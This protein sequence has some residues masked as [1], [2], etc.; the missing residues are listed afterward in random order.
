MA[1]IAPKSVDE[2]SHDPERMAHAFGLLASAELGRWPDWDGADAPASLRARIEVL[3]ILLN[4]VPRSEI[5]RLDELI[6]AWCREFAPGRCTTAIELR[7][8]VGRVVRP[9]RAKSDHPTLDENSFR[10]AM[11]LT[12]SRENPVTP[13]A[14]PEPSPNDFSDKQAQQQCAFGLGVWLTQVANHRRWRYLP[15]IVPGEAATEIDKAYVELYAISDGDAADIGDAAQVHSKRLPRRMLASQYP[16]VSVPTMV[17]RTMHRCIVMGEPGGGKSTLVQWLAWATHNNKCPDFDVAL[18]VKLSAFAAALAEKPALSLIEFF[19]DSLDTNIVDWCPGAYW[20]RRL[21]AESH[22][23]LL[24]LD[25]WDEVPLP[26]REAVREQIERESHAFVT[27]ITSRPSGLPRQFRDG[28]SVDFYHIAGLASGAIENLVRKLLTS[29]GKPELSDPILTRIR[30]EP[31]L[32]EMA[33]NPFLLGLLVRVLTRVSDQGVVPRTRSEVYRQITSWVQELHN[34]SCPQALQLTVEHFAALRRLSHALLFEV[35]LPRY[36]FRSR[37]LAERLSG[38][39]LEPILR[40]R[41]V[42]RVDPVF[43][44]FAFLHATLQEYFAAE[45]AGTLAPQQLDEMMDR[46]FFS[47]SRLI[48]LEFIAGLEGRASVQCREKVVHWF[49]HR[50]R[51]QQ[52]LFRVARIA[53]AGRWPADD[54]EGFGRS[55]R[56]ALCAEITQSQ[57][58][59][60]T[61]EAIGVFA[62]LDPIDLARRARENRNLD[63]WAIRCCVDSVPRPIG[64]KERL[65]ELVGEEWKDHGKLDA[66]D[67][68]SEIELKNN[69]T[70]LMDPTSTE[71]D[72]RTAII[73]ARAARDAGAVPALLKMLSP[74]YKLRE[75]REQAIE[76]LG[77]IGSRDAIDSLVGIVLGHGDIPDDTVSIVTAVLRQRGTNCQALDPPGRDRLVQRLAILPPDNLRLAH[78]LAALE[79][80]PLRDGADVIAYLARW[81]EGHIAIRYAAIRVLAT[82][83]DRRIVQRVVETIESEP[84]GQVADWLLDLAVRRAV[85]VPNLWLEKKILAARDKVRRREFFIAYLMLLPLRTGSER[86]H[87]SEFLHRH[88]VKALG[89][90]SQNAIELAEVL[91][92]ALSRAEQV[93]G[94]VFPDETLGISLDVLAKFTRTP[95]K[96]PIEHVMLAANLIGRFGKASARKDLRRALDA[97]LQLGERT[98]QE[99]DQISQTLARVLAAIAPDELLDYSL[100][101]DCV[102]SALCL[103]A[104]QRGWLVF[105]D[106]ILDAEGVEIA[107]IDAPGDSDNA[108]PK[109]ADLISLC[110]HLSPPQEKVLQS[111][112]LM[113]KDDTP[114]RPSDTLKAIYAAVQARHRGETVDELA[115][116]LENLFPDALPSFD[117]WRKTLNRIEK[118]F[119]AQPDMAEYLRRIGLGRQRRKS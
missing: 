104:V 33:A 1:K 57:N 50:D 52:V 119:A 20:L 70:T 117:T 111:Y 103:L 61:K 41:F 21:A 43:D 100:D 101:C 114:C 69:R 7:E 98:K 110:K 48:V 39:S 118:R 59:A 49:Q 28:D 42:D 66:R 116:Y 91:D 92:H 34:Q 65:D 15:G 36:L 47:T 107:R 11:E 17:A 79:G 13:I 94:R 84:S 90:D 80:H 64:R 23:F 89:D 18:V 56:D 63:N 58:M 44:E 45:C 5:D 109:P 31:D 112:W 46:A 19:F 106:R 83:M 96:T 68:P 78:I 32:G 8:S 55:L 25:G 40:S 72:I 71:S 82:V 27:V 51:F 73:Y 105:N 14:L 35:D 37:D 86:D 29:F 85:P 38:H 102:Q 77:T 10:K 75:L 87:A 54:R 115:E 81:T 6:E 26:Q 53:A 93:M 16:V 88:V 76:C 24:L 99:P 22:R 12:R 3:A 108:M 9:E 67:G 2:A 60:L 97:A 4:V 62:D 30:E 113:V 95:E 74:D